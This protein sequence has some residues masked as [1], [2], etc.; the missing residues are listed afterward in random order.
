MS[1]IHCGNNNFEKKNLKHCS[2]P[3]KDHY[4]VKLTVDLNVDA[5]SSCGAEAFTFKDISRIDNAIIESIHN[6]QEKCIKSLSLIGV[7]QK[8]LAAALGVTPTYISNAKKKK[9]EMS[10]TLFNLLRVFTDNPAMINQYTGVEINFSASK[11]W[12]N[13][14]PK[15]NEIEILA[16]LTNL[17]NSQ[18]LH[19]LTNEVE[20]SD[21][22]LNKKDS[23]PPKLYRVA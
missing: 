18:T 9:V 23:S 15:I 8:K 3:W 6:E 20:F 12:E 17:I 14:F 2:Y 16:D 4:Q 7:N 10:F 21:E 5:C 22:H 1:C 11:T 13:I 19:P